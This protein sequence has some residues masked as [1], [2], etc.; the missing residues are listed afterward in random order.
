MEQGTEYW[1][2]RCQSFN[3]F[4][5]MVPVILCPSPIA[6]GLQPHFPPKV[7]SWQWF[8]APLWGCIACKY[9]F[10]LSQITYIIF[11]QSCLSESNGG[12]TFNCKSSFLVQESSPLP[13]LTLGQRNAFLMYYSAIWV[14]HMAQ[15]ALSVN[16]IC[17]SVMGK[18][19]ILLN[20]IFVIYKM[21]VIP[22]IHKVVLRLNKLCECV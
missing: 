18:L 7:S 4:P 8:K 9:F 6:E 14:W 21:I 5:L 22:L 15:R 2:G 11:I 12:D 17:H 16:P 3:L 1:E 13:V 20:P 19:P 10:I